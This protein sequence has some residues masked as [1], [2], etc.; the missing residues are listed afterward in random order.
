MANADVSKE[1]ALRDFQK[2]SDILTVGG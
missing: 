1:P 2:K